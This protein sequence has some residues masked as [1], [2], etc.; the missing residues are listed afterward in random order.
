MCIWNMDFKFFASIYLVN[1]LYIFI[2]FSLI[3]P[4]EKASLQWNRN[5]AAP[6]KNLWIKTSY[7]ID[8]MWLVLCDGYW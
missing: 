6:N 3:L 1:L 5:I 7:L 8:V 4:T 2:Q